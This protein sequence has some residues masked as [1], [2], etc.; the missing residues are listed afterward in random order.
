MYIY[1]NKITF[2]H[3][4]LVL[5]FIELF[6]SA[7]GLWEYDYTKPYM[8]QLCAIRVLNQRLRRNDISSDCTEAQC[9][10]E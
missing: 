10:T 7:M 1:F 9:R 6:Y 4:I 5:F 8:K 3:S 2:Q